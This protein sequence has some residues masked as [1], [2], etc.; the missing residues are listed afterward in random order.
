MF[1][2]SA[3]KFFERRKKIRESWGAIAQVVQAAFSIVFVIGKAEDET[4]TKNLMKEHHRYGDIL[5]YD[6]PD[7]YR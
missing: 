2:K 5:Q 4:L 6:G 1:V 3:A 7:D